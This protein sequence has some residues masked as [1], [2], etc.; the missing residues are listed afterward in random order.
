MIITRNTGSNIGSDFIRLENVKLATV[1]DNTATNVGGRMVHVIEEK[2]KPNM[3]NTADRAWHEH[4]YGKISIG[5][6]V[7]VISAIIIKM[8]LKL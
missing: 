3:S 8:L 7:A 4:A 6:V 2:T 1:E 5:I